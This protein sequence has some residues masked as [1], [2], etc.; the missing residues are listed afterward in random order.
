M[1]PD[2]LRKEAQKE[3]LALLQGIVRDLPFHPE[4][5]NIR[6]SRTLTPLAPLAKFARRED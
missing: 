6:R 5:P 4:N 2:L 1:F 3:F